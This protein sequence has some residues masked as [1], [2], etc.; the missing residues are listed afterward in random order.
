MDDN[1]FTP[2]FVRINVATM[3]HLV[4]SASKDKMFQWKYRGSTNSQ[5][6]W[7]LVKQLF[8]GTTYLFRT[9]GHKFGCKRNIWHLGFDS[10]ANLEWLLSR[11][12]SEYWKT[13]PHWRIFTREGMRWFLL[14]T[15]PRSDFGNKKEDAGLLFVCRVF[16]LDTIHTRK[17][18]PNM[19]WP[20]SFDQYLSCPCVV[21]LP[22]GE[23][24]ETVGK[25]TGATGI[26][27]W[28]LSYENSI[29]EIFRHSVSLMKQYLVSYE[30]QIN[31]HTNDPVKCKSF[32]N[33]VR[34]SS[35]S[36]SFLSICSREE[37]TDRLPVRLFSD[38]NDWQE[39]S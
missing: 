7:E 1:I 3:K 15:R 10:F 37:S 2:K 27:C 17:W 12:V 34:C 16:E 26:I 32:V 11:A 25:L 14:L 38:K 39:T 30:N 6:R 29:N 28:K 13:V 8:S 5:R 20:I 9:L 19:K 23:K 36:N 31:P 4:S 22:Q 18:T 21:F 33:T 24:W 35:D